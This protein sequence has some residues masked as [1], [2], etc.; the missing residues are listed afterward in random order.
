[1]ADTL[2]LDR[3]SRAILN[4]LTAAHPEPLPILTLALML[5]PEDPERRC[6][7]TVYTYVSR[8]RMA[9]RLAR[10]AVLVTSI[11]RRDGSRAYGLV[12]AETGRPG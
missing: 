12:S 4:A 11:K 8:L 10:A 7:Q 2:V 9:Q 1:M 5:W 6:R 3:N